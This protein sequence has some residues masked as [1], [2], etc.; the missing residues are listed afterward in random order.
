MA[1]LTFAAQGQSG[2]KRNGAGEVLIVRRK[3]LPKSHEAVRAAG[4]NRGA[5][6]T[7]GDRRDLRRMPERRSQRLTGF[8]VPDAGAAINA[9]RHEE[10]TVRTEGGGANG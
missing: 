5:I 3:P 6:G 10:L 7:E 8:H 4:H 2:D 1:Q 9:A